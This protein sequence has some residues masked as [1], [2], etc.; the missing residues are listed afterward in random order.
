[1]KVDKKTITIPIVREGANVP[2]INGS[3][4]SPKELELAEIGPHIRSALPHVEPKIDFMGRWSSHHYN[5]WNVASVEDD[6]F[7][8][9]CGPSVVML[10]NKNLSGAQKEFLLWHNKLGISMP[11]V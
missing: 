7:P 2:I 3:A 8:S 5:M 10:G 11:R 4:V 9:F 1:M 6:V